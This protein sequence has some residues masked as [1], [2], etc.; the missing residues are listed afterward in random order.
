MYT[1]EFESDASVVVIM[2]EADRHEDVEVVLTDNNE[3]YIRQY[4]ESLDSHELICMSYQQLMDLVASINS[5]EGM[6]KL[7]FVRG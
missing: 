6:F 7:Q 3:V 2:D 5:S 1:V 4:E